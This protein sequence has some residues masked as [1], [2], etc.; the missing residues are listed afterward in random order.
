MI[1][2]R[3][4][5][6]M[7]ATPRLS[8][9]PAHPQRDPDR[10]PVSHWKLPDGRTWCLVYRTE[11]VFRMRFPGFADFV[12]D[13]GMEVS[14]IPV[15]GVDIP[16]LRH[17]YANQVVPAAFSL[18]QRFVF[19]GSAV[20]IN[21]IGVGFFG[22][23]GR[24]KSTLATFMASRGWPLLTDDGLELRDSR[25]DV[26]AIPSAASVRLWQDS[27]DALLPRAVQPAPAVSYTRKGCFEAEGWLPRCNEPVPFRLAFFLDDEGATEPCIST[28]S[29]RDAHMAWI[30]NSFLLDTNDKD[31]IR[32]Q[33]FRIGR[34]V[35]ASRC[36]RLDYPRDYSALPEVESAVLNV[37]P[38]EAP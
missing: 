24:G 17:L 16:T 13:A 3:Q 35:R 32:A 18:Q 33:F 34:I 38:A 12:F 15:E 31:I 7:P 1:A 8:L 26:F 4:S 9:R 19:H 22:V 21:G 25:E 5:D 27:Q 36:F 2:P 14:C 29:P 6:E 28:L 20:S 11:D 23:S 37:M 30:G 10:A